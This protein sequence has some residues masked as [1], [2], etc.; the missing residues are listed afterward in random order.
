[1]R[2]VVY[3]VRQA[4]RY[5]ELAL[6]MRSLANL[7]HGHVWVF[8]ARPPWLAGN[9]VHV[10]VRQGN[11]RHENTAAVTAA[12]ARNT[13]ISKEFYW[14]HDDMFV[15]QPVAEVPRLHRGPWS[16]WASIPASA[17]KARETERIL[18]AF[19]KP[20][21]LSYELHIPMLVDRDEFAAMAEAVTMYDPRALIVAAKRSLYGNWVGLGGEQVDDVKFRSTSDKIPADAVFASTSDHSVK[22]GPGREVR[23]RFPVPGPYEALDAFGKM[24]NVPRP[25][26]VA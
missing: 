19:G 10:P 26:R 8:G 3:M 14:F 25:R 1:M 18:A 6:S 22:S 21:E 20:C 15:L 7:P 9:V 2:D 17:D 16:T 12:I 5:D 4:Y 13:G 11:I 24:P 23:R